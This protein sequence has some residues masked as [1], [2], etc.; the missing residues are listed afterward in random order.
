MRA[1]LILPLIALC[2][3]G[4]SGQGRADVQVPKQLPPGMTPAVYKMIMTPGPAHPAGLPADV[5]PYFGCIPTMGYHYVNP[6]NKPFGPIYGWY[7]GKPT[8]TE[9]MVAE[10]LFA[11]GTSWDE[12]LKPLPGYH[13]D[14]VDIWWE[15]HGH[16]GYEAPH[17]D[18]HAWYV[19]HAEHMKFCNNPSGTKP[20]WLGS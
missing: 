9:I 15:P 16:P 19:P 11:K 6:K 12:V 3:L 14:H 7:N 18:I 1:R 8:F 10:S 17:Y 20:A 2:L 4:W 5:Q 13:I